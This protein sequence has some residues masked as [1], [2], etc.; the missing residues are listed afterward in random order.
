MS[1]KRPNQ[2]GK[3]QLSF[4]VSTGGWEEIH[5]HPGAQERENLPPV[6]FE[7]SQRLKSPS[8][9]RRNQFLNPQRQA[10]SKSPTLKSRDSLSSSVTLGKFSV[11]P[12]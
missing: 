4:S 3:F 9:S 2:V 10:R 8:I 11:A 1:F 6:Y 12:G 5:I 7:C